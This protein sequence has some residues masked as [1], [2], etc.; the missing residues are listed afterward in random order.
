[1]AAFFWIHTGANANWNTVG[2]WSATSGGGSNA[3]TPTTTSDVTFDGAGASGNTASTCNVGSILTLTFTAGYTSTVTINTA[4]ILTIAGNFTDNTAHSWTVSG[5]GSITIS[6][7]S[8]I[9]S[10]G[11]TFP[12][13]VT[14]SGANTKTLSTNDWTITGTLTTGV[15]NTVLNGQTLNCAGIN[16]TGGA[17][18]S[19]TTVINLTGGTWSGSGQ[20]QTSLSFA[21]TI[22]VAAGTVTYNTGTMTYTSGTVTTTGATMVVTASTTFNTAGITWDAVNING[23]TITLNSLFTVTT[24]QLSNTNNTQINFAGT[25]GFSVNTLTSPAT[26]VVTWQFANGVTYTITT[27][28]QVFSARGGSRPL[29]TSD[30][31]T[32]KAIITLNQGATC[33]VSADATRIDSSLGRTINSFHGIL[34]TTINWFAYTDYNGTLSSY[35]FC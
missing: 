15:A 4:V 35:L 19:G 10:G 12:G 17:G 29:F 18:V 6:A 16:M 28:L 21:G 13:P 30:S 23:A 33:S 32:I 24:L 5:T 11:K 7:A 34:T 26:A 9:N 20:I 2:N 8:T 14:F 1:M 25:F 27:S 3:A 31:G 22:T